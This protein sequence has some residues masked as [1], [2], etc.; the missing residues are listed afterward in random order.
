[1]PL[2]DRTVR[3]TK[4]GTKPS[5]L[6]D[7]TGTNAVRPRKPVLNVHQVGHIEAVSNF[8]F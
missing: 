8:D 3:A 1:M 2:T 4:P 6:S 7:E 5:K